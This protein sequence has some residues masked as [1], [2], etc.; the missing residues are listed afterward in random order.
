[1]NQALQYAPTP[2]YVYIKDLSPF[3]QVKKYMC[4]F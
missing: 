1:M 2:G 4:F 3:G